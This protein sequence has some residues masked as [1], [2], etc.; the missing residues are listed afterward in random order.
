ML[1]SLVGSE[2]CIR[3][4]TKIDITTNI[5]LNGHIKFP[6]MNGEVTKDGGGETFNLNFPSEHQKLLS[7]D[8]IKTPAVTQHNDGRLNQRISNLEHSYLDFDRNLNSI[9][10]MLEDMKVNTGRCCCKCS[11]RNTTT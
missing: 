2:M 3:D 5:H 11:N 10:A 1:R 7:A 8:P 6:T 9:M 4:S